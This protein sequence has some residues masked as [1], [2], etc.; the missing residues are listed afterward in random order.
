MQM[1]CYFSCLGPY[2][3]QPTPMAALTAKE[4]ADTCLAG[5]KGRVILPNRQYFRKDARLFTTHSFTN[6]MERP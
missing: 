6:S 4:A 2:C 1:F 3:F 5:G